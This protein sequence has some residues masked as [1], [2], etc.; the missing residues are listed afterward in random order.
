MSEETEDGLNEQLNN[1]LIAKLPIWRGAIEIEPLVGGLTNTNYLVRRGDEKFVV[2]LAQD[3]PQFHILRWNEVAASRA[4]HKVG[5]SPEVIHTESGVL[6][7]RFIE[8]RTL[9]AADFK[10]VEQLDAAVGLVRRFQNEIPKVW[11]GPMLSVWPFQMVRSFGAW[12]DERECR[13]AKEWPEFLRI[14]DELESAVDPISL[15]FCHNDLLPANFIDDGDRLWLIDW[16]YAG[17]SATLFDL[18]GISSNSEL[19]EAQEDY[20]LE[21]YLGSTASKELK[22]R[23]L[24]FVAVSALQEAAW[25]MM[26]EINASKEYDYVGYTDTCLKRLD[27]TL[28]RFRT[29]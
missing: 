2:R 3:I 7:I 22:R 27:V 8:G 14:N 17:Y 15:S 5:I 4:A 26:Q 11:Q 9:E 25:S 13:L 29:A 16:E 1:D 23:Y 24:A 21:A 20:L 6:V 12:L 10:H 18:A 28:Q 19:G